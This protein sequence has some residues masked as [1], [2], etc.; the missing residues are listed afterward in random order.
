[1]VGALSPLIPR[2]LN[3]QNN[4]FPSQAP[5]LAVHTLEKENNHYWNT[6]ISN[7]NSGFS[8]EEAFFFT[9][10]TRYSAFTFQVPLK[11][12]KMPV[13]PHVSSGNTFGFFPPSHTTDLKNNPWQEKEDSQAWALLLL[14]LVTTFTERN[15]KIMARLTWKYQIDQCWD[16][17]AVSWMK[18]VQRHRAGSAAKA[19]AKI[20]GTSWRDIPTLPTAMQREK[21]SL[22]Q[23][24]IWKD[25][26]WPCLLKQVT[27]PTQEIVIQIQFIVKCSDLQNHWW[28]TPYYQ[29]T[30]LHQLLRRGELQ[31]SISLLL[32]L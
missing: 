1:M 24:T 22:N 19:G 7:Y 30:L 28:L 29:S 25:C 6:N 15:R 26:Y 5:Q 16:E 31:Q 21:N 32:C 4:R 2:L 17:V 23:S 8:L 18:P 9:R 13:C 11:F 3:M 12:S 10:V 14:L 27:V 20:T